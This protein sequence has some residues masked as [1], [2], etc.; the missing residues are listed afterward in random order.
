MLVAS[1]EEENF[2]SGP[3]VSSLLCSQL[4]MSLDSSASTPKFMPLLL[5][6][7]WYM[8]SSV[9]LHPPPRTWS[10]K[11]S[12]RKQVGIKECFLLACLL[13]VIMSNS[14]LPLSLIYIVFPKAN[15]YLRFALHWVLERRINVGNA[16]T[17]SCKSYHLRLREWGQQFSIE[18]GLS[19]ACSLGEESLL[20]HGK[21]H[22]EKEIQ[23]P[24]MM[25]E[26]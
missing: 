16:I 17:N 21:W 4:H 8:S 19:I 15:F 13:G 14:S 1:R 20:P 23:V 18:A 24:N 10:Y 25:E 6:L 3:T 9:P 22:T 7:P 11:W 26:E 2:L 12:S 5:S